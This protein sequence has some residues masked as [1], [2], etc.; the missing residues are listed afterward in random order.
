MFTVIRFYQNDCSVISG[1]DN[2]ANCS[3]VDFKILSAF[4]LF[5]EKLG[6]GS[7]AGDR[8]VAVLKRTVCALFLDKAFNDLST[9]TTTASFGIFSLATAKFKPCHKIKI[10][11]FDK[12]LEDRWMF[13]YGII[14]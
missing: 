8:I 9:A 12:L 5:L 7:F 14:C 3:I 6:V 10:L 13:C 1:W 2:N 11:A 4:L